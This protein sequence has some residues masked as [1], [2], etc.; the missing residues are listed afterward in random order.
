VR[1]TL[2][3]AGALHWRHGGGGVLGARLATRAGRAGRRSSDERRRRWWGDREWPRAAGAA[4]S[5]FSGTRAVKVQESHQATGYGGHAASAPPT[6][7][8]RPGLLFGARVAAAATAH[9]QGRRMAQGTQALSRH[10]D[11]APGPVRAGAGHAAGREQ[12][13]RARWRRVREAYGGRV[14]GTASAAAGRAAGYKRRGLSP[15]Q[16][17]AGTG[18]KGARA[19]PRRCGRTVARRGAAS[20]P[21]SPAASG[22]GDGGARCAARARLEPEGGR[23]PRASAADGRLPSGG[24]S[25]GLVRACGQGRG[26]GQGCRGAPHGLAAGAPSRRLPPPGERASWAGWNGNKM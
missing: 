24:V 6:T 8:S 2:Q 17:P 18:W 26:G 22:T 7:S 11:G 14:G 13:R 3:R 19:E 12:G 4:H 5:A 9:R 15:A 21:R 16:E 25:W 20:P 10:V 23:C 1:A